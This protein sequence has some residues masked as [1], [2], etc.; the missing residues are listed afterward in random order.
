VE[1]GKWCRDGGL[2]GCAEHTQAGV[3]PALL[4]LRTHCSHSCRWAGGGEGGEQEG[5]LWVWVVGGCADGQV[6]ALAMLGEWA[7]RVGG[8]EGTRVQHA[9]AVA[10]QGGVW[11]QLPCYFGPGTGHLLG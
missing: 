5:R 4:L 11:V 6:D 1:Q 2:M 7:G 3:P 9:V 8:Q 10:H